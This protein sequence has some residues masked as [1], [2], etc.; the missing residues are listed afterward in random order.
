M[1]N[2]FG[3]IV[4]IH[5]VI[6]RTIHLRIT[7]LRKSEGNPLQRP[8][9]GERPTNRAQ[10]HQKINTS[11]Q[12]TQRPIDTG[13]ER[14]TATDQHNKWPIHSD[15]LTLID[16]QNS[17]QNDQST[18]TDCLV[19]PR[20]SIVQWK[21]STVID[22]HPEQFRNYKSVRGSRRFQNHLMD[23]GDRNSTLESGCWM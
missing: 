4:C 13:I 16:S 21:C 10:R 7:G 19:R 23:T 11:N 3:M 12:P 17:A 22:A 20:A 14:R 1:L 2:V 9:H 18:A 6:D 5:F 15:R 8:T